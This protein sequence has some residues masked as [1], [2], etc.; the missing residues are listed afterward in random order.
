MNGP[1]TPPS[2]RVI[3]IDVAT[4]PKNVGLAL[5]TIHDGRPQLEEVTTG[6]SWPAIDEQVAA[7]ATKPALLALDAD[8]VL[9]APLLADVDDHDGL[10]AAYRRLG[11]S[12][13]LR[14]RLGQ[15]ATIRAGAFDVRRTVRRLETIYAGTATEIEPARSR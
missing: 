8:C 10:A 14:R 7:W 12:P 3:G 5:C 9:Y 13:E 4:D 11:S 2:I 6:R 15:A 1:A